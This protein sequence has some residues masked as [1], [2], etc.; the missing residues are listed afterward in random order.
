MNNNDIL[1]RVRYIFNFNDDRMMELFALGGRPASR[2]EISDWLK[3]DDDPAFQPIND[4]LLATFLNGLIVKKRGRK[5]ETPMAVEERINNNIVFR[6]LRIALQLRDDDI[7]AILKKAGFVLSRH[8]LSAFF[9][10][11][12]Q[13]Q[14]RPCKDQ[15]LRNF[16]H[17]LQIVHRPNP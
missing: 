10:N 1:R 4:H 17:G 13:N 15:I 6:K 9:R 7:L 8:E 12:Q 16:L 14:Y 3:R 11:P 2:A 5:D